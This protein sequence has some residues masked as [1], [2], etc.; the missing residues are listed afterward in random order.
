MSCFFKVDITDAVAP[1]LRDAV[2]KRDAKIWRLE[3]G[4]VMVRHPAS[5]DTRF[6]LDEADAAEQLLRGN[7]PMRRRRP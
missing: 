3:L 7:P 1:E 5:L 6:F 2:L 4:T